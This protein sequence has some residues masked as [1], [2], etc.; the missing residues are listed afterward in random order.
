MLPGVY[1]VGLSF[2]GP[3]TS[4][5]NIVASGATIADVIALNVQA[6]A[7]VRIRGPELVGTSFA[8]SCGEANTTIS[9]VTIEDANLI[10]GTESANAVG[11][12]ASEISISSSKL[13]V[14]DG[15][16]ISI[17]RGARFTG[18]RLQ[19]AGTQTFILMIFDNVHLTL[20]NSVIEDPVINFA[21][22]GTLASSALFAFNTIVF[23]SINEIQCG[24]LDDNLTARFHN[25][26]VVGNGVQTSPVITG[27]QCELIS[28]IL[29][30]Q[31]SPPAT[32]L[33]V[34]PMFVDPS[35]KDFRVQ[36]SSPA[37]DTADASVVFVPDHDFSG[38]VR[39]QGIGHDIGAF[40]Q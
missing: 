26:I 4:P 13:T 31:P 23:T 33:D 6:G 11:G 34:D 29:H 19:I 12:A 15:G 25:N 16:A 22:G 8:V 40:E 36:A 14:N 1:L 21:T 24:A 3:T 20:T 9:K 38:A 7:E 32:N 39:P 37:V 17:A 35:T 5:I 18:D 30:P 10:A 27:T 28:N 2:N